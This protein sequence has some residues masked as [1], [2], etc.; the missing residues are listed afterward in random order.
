MTQTFIDTIVVC[1][2]TG[3]VI[4]EMGVWDSGLDGAPLTVEAFSVGLGGSIGGYVVSLTLIFFAYSTILGWSYYGEKSIEYL[5]GEAVIM[6]YR[7]IFVI[8]A[9]IG[10]V[11]QLDL[12]WQLADTMNA[13]MAIPN[14]VGLLLLAGVT[15][16]LT[17][18]YIAEKKSG[19]PT[20]GA[21]GQPPLIS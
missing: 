14:L 5:F 18:E 16:R 11:L 2:M 19:R 10:S 13:A 15:R 20:T 17:R 12:V 7:V 21:G 4:I 3:F 6:P 1:S 9:F 8:V